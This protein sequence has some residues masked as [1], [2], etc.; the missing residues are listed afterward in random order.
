[1]AV[2]S[3]LLEKHSSAIFLKA[4]VEVLHAVIRVALGLGMSIL[5]VL[6]TSVSHSIRVSVRFLSCLAPAQASADS[7]PPPTSI[8][9]RA[10][11]PNT[12]FLSPFLAAMAAC[13]STL[14]ICLSKLATTFSSFL[15]DLTADSRHLPSTVLPCIL[16]FFLSW[17]FFFPGLLLFLLPGFFTFLLLFLPD[18]F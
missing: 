1:M 6:F 2:S 18:F 17:V 16:V 9:L 11:G 8:S 12:A 13:F 5:Q 14:I 10:M 15:M 3:L 4:L 7:L